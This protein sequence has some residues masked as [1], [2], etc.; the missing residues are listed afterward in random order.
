M[1]KNLHAE[2]RI[3]SRSLSD[4]NAE[5]TKSTIRDGLGLMT[6]VDRVEFI[7]ALEEELLRLKMD[8]RSYLVPLGIPARSPEDLTPNEVGHFVRF[9]KI[10]MPYALVAVERAMHG[11]EAFNSGNGKVHRRLAA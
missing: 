3:G 7:R 2:K 10:N 5:E 4:L 6:L 11:F 9:L 1:A 8:I